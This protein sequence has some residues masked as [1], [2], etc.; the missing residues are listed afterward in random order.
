[1]AVRCDHSAITSDSKYL[2]QLSNCQLIDTIF[3]QMNPVHMLVLQFLRVDFCNILTLLVLPSYLL[4]SGFPTKIVCAF[5]VFLVSTT[6]PAHP[7]RNRTAVTVV[8]CDAC[9]SCE[10]RPIVTDTDLKQVTQCDIHCFVRIVNW[11]CYML[12]RYMSANSFVVSCST[13]EGG[14]KCVEKL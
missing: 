10:G 12:E 11:L 9:C 7:P 4:P 6:C 5:L 13:N 1:V 8:L 2:D 3:I 14:E